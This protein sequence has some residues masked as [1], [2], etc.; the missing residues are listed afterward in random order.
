MA[1]TV[2]L[3]SSQVAHNLNELYRSNLPTRAAAAAVNNAVVAAHMRVFRY[4]SWASN[5]VNAQLLQKLRQDIEADFSASSSKISKSLRHGPIC[6]RRRRRILNALQAKLAQYQSTAN[7]VLDVGSTDAA[8]ATM[9]LGQ[10]DDRFTSIEND[11]R[12]IL[13]AITAQSD[14]IVENL[15]AATSDRNA[16]AGDRIAHLPRLQHCRDRLHRQID[17]QADHVDHERHAEI[18]DRRHRSQIGLSRSRR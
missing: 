16:I 6:R 11:I 14:T 3:T 17:R 13:T 8:M 5:G 4:V 12:K 10:T 2:A 1:V 15:S 9:M 7:D 18:V